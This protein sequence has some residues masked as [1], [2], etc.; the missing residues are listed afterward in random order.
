MKNLCLLFLILF[1]FNSFS[2]NLEAR[3]S[4]DLLQGATLKGIEPE[5]I[6]LSTFKG[7]IYPEENF[8]KGQITDKLSNKTIPSFLRYDA[9]ND[10]FQMNETASTTGYSY[11]KKEVSLGL[12]YNNT[13]FVYTTFVNEEGN[14]KLGYLQELVSLE[15]TTIYYRMEKIIT[16]PQKGAN[17]YEPDS[18]GKINSNDYYV[19]KRGD[20]PAMAEKINKKNITSFF[21]KEQGKRVLQIT[22]SEKLKFRDSKDMITLTKLLSKG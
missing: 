22:K 9:Y 14:S 20:K 13:A 16:L 19:V 7:S 21:P 8:S 6:D 11:L 3:T 2:Q 15:G 18:P 4:Y 12:T 1:S 17:S 10:A 5:S